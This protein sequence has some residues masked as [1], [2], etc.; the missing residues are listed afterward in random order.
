MRRPWGLPFLDTVAFSS[1]LHWRGSA[2][3]TSRAPPPAVRIAHGAP[4]AHPRVRAR[5]ACTLA[6]RNASAVP[7]ISAHRSEGVPIPPPRAPVPAVRN[8]RRRQLR[9]FS[10]AAPLLAPAAAQRLKSNS[11]TTIKPSAHPNGE[12]QTQP[13]HSQRLW[14][15]RQPNG[16]SRTQR[17][18]SSLP[19][20]PTAKLKP[21]RDSHSVCALLAPAGAQ[22]RTRTR[23]QSKA[24]LDRGVGG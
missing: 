4:R 19:R 9:R 16:E 2:Q 14:Q 10:R 24:P 21:S 15:Q 20:I 17:Q 22:R 18:R 8:A 13:R 12:T 5:F 3:P 7:A 23:T 11:A 1:K 6:Q